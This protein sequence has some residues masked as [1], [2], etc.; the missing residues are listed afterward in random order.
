LLLANRQLLPKDS[1]PH[2][3]CELEFTESVMKRVVPES[4]IL[5]A[6]VKEF[7]SGI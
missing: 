7:A 6:A 5:A 4:R 2:C 3:V 1:P